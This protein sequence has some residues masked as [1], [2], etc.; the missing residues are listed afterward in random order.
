M[1]VPLPP[2]FKRKTDRIRKLGEPT[3]LP[4]LSSQRINLCWIDHADV[5]SIF[6]IYS[7]IEVARYW[8]QPSFTHQDDAHIYIESIHHGF[9]DG[10]LFQWGVCLAGSQKLIGTCSLSD[11]STSQGRANIGIAISSSQWGHGYGREA[12]STLIKHAFTE[13]GLRRL[14]ADVS[15]H[16][17]ACLKLLAALGF[18]RE[19]YLRQR[20]LVEG[21]LQDSIVLGL[22]KSDCLLDV[23]TPQTQSASALV[24]QG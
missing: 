12:M 22:L 3:S 9:D 20:W 6:Q 13:L 15:P 19:G 24:S 5:A 10:K 7:D 4:T 17:A 18:K 16:N 21:E 11:I 2:F 8:N 23:W 1:T 14:E